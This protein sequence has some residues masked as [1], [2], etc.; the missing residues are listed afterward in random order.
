MYTLYSIQYM[1]IYCTVLVEL[2][3]TV[4]HTVNAE[5][6]IL[7]FSPTLL[8]RVMVGLVKGQAV[9]YDMPVNKNMQA[10][11]TC[12]SIEDMLVNR[13]H[14][15]QMEMLVTMTCWSI[16]HS[17]LLDMFRTCW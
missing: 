14:A 1:L 17:V 6:T 7:F 11:R 15:G 12:W 10:N 4:L 5:L 16:G 2:H 8:W 9:Q 3:C 13:G